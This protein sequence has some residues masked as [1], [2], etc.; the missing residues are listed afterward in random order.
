MIGPFSRLRQVLTR[1]VST[2]PASRNRK[3]AALLARNAAFSGFGVK[4]S[5]GHRIAQYL[6]GSAQASGADLDGLP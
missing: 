2:V 5:N 3:T 1:E 6:A 4:H